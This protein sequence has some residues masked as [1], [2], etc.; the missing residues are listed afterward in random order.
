MLPHNNIFVCILILKIQSWFCRMKVLSLSTID[1]S[2]RS[3]SQRE[4]NKKNTLVMILMY[5]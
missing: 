3:C 4:T 2:L 5:D 1:S